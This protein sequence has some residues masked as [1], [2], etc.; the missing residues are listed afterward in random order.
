MSGKKKQTLAA[1][2]SHAS[3][4]AVSAGSSRASRVAC[5]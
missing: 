2:G 5:I 1:S 4:Q 3:A